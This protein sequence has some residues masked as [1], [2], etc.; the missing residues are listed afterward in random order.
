MRPRDWG[1][2]TPGRQDR[3]DRE[4]ESARLASCRVRILAE[5][6]GSKVGQRRHL[7]C[8]KDLLPTRG[9]DH[10]PATTQAGG[11][12]DH[13]DSVLVSEHGS[14]SAGRLARS[15]PHVHV[16]ADSRTHEAIAIDTAMSLGCLAGRPHRGAWLAAQA[17]RVH[18]RPLGPCGRQRGRAGLDAR[19]PAWRRSPHRRTSRSTA[20]CSCTR[21]RSSRRFPSR[22]AFR[23]WNWPK[24]AESNSARSTSRSCTR[25]DTSRARSGLLDR[26]NS[27]LLSGD[28][29]FAGSWG[30]TDLP[31]GS[32]EQ[33]A[34]SLSRLVG[35]DDRLTVLPGHG[36]ATTIGARTPLARM[37]SGRTGRCLAEA[38]DGPAVGVLRRAI[39]WRPVADRPSRHSSRLADLRRIALFR[40]LRAI[41]YN[42]F[43]SERDQLSW[44]SV[45]FPSLSLPEPPL[46]SWQ[47]LH[48]DPV[49][50][51]G[52]Q[53]CP[54]G[55][56]SS[57]MRLPNVATTVMRLRP[58][59]NFAAPNRQP[60]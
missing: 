27:L 9:A 5:D 45:C 54:V 20:R 15:G 40:G 37:G 10:V 8:A 53:P 23:Q 30:R 50:R 46:P 1:R 58:R 29:L 17:H 33:M 19:A 56:G 41:C 32:E 4:G 34:E 28:T 7:E 57:P 35:L 44:Q 59:H 24:V 38:R 21:S 39:L 36:S 49:I 60:G 2:R 43:C 51:C 6:D 48:F 47:P 16:L 14:S 3:R 55:P 31:G 42:S 12:R 13:F 11:Q 25:R 26:T 18:P 22:P 52:S